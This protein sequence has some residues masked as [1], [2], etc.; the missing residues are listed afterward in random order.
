[1]TNVERFDLILENGH[2]LPDV[3]CVGGPADK[4]WPGRRVVRALRL[5]G[6]LRCP[7]LGILL[8]NHWAK[9]HGAL[10]GGVYTAMS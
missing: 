10:L 8:R 7:L 5:R 9:R 4:R 6:L 1:M 2:Y 3:C